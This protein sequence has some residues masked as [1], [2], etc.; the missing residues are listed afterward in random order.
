MP[1]ERNFKEA[2]EN[3]REGE[4]SPTSLLEYL[5]ARLAANAGNAG[6]RDG[7]AEKMSELYQS[8]DLDPSFRVAEMEYLN[9]CLRSSLDEIY[10]IRDRIEAIVSLCEWASTQSWQSVGSGRI[11]PLD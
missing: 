7:I 4:A 6:E 11:Y 3:S 8:D 10:D 2:Q 1:P 5:E 9:G